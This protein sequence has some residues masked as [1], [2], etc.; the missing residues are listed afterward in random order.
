M[1]KTTLEFFDNLNLC[2]SSVGFDSVI[3]N[4]PAKHYAPILGGI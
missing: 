3:I 4:F 1:T 2:I